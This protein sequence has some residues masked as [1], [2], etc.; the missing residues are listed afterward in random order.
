MKTLNLIFVTILVNMFTLKATAQNRKN[1]QSYISISTTALQ[2]HLPTN[3]YTVLLYKDGKMVDSVLNKEP[4]S[5]DFILHVNEVYTLVFKKTGFENYTV[6]VNTIIPD[7][8]NETLGKSK[9]LLVCMK[10]M[11]YNSSDDM[12]NEVLIIDKDQHR[13]VASDSYQQYL[14]QSRMMT[15]IAKQ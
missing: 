15:G 12:P 1:Y 7:G 2:N 11:L 9:E 10:P 5:I 13:L 14:N 6:I 3:N 8:F 4:N